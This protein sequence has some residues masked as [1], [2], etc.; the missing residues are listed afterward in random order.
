MSEMR[1]VLVVED[2]AIVAMFLTKV[3]NR[4]GY[5]KHCVVSTGEE[6]LAA[7]ERE[8]PDVILMDVHLGGKLNGVQAAGH[9]RARHEI[10]IIFMT[11]YNAADI[12]EQ[13]RHLSRTG[14]A[15]KP[16][17]IHELARLLTSI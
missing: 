14:Y 7:V 13:T 9:I 11:G 3:L 6:A 5:T 2:E 16:T 12:Q 8:V 15:E 1:S 4:L 17:S 10:P